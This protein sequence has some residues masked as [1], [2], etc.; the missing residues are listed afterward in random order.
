MKSLL[1]VERE[2]LAAREPPAALDKTVHRSSLLVPELPG[3]HSVISFL[4]HFLIKRGISEVS[5]RIT[6]VDNA[7][8]RI[9]QRMIPVNQHRV[10][11]IDLAPLFPNSRPNNYIVEFYSAQ[12]LAIPF[13][14]VMVNHFGPNTV[15]MV[16]AYNRV[17]N[18]VF[19]QDGE[20]DSAPAE[21][22]IDLRIDKDVDT[23]VVFTSGPTPFHGELTF[24]LS[25]SSGRRTA[26]LSLEMPRLTQ[27][28][29]GLK[30]VFPDLADGETGI[31][32]VHAPR[33]FLFFGRMLAGQRTADGAIAANHTYYDTSG[34][35][36]YFPNNA[37]SW[38]IHPFM[39]ELRNLVRVYPF[40]S[41][42][43]LRFT[44]A[45]NDHHGAEVD[46]FPAGELVSPSDEF[47]TADVNAALKS[48]GIDFESVGGFVLEAT[49]VSGNTPT[50]IPHQRVFG[51]GGLEASVVMSM[52]NKNHVP[53][54]RGFVWGQLIDGGDFKSY[55]GVSRTR[56]A[57]PQAKLLLQLYG[58]GGKVCESEIAIPP[59]SGR[60]F[61]LAEL[62]PEND[63][64][65]GNPAFLWYLI[66]GP[67]PDFWAHS[68]V[69]DR[70][71]NCTA[72]H[73]FS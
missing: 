57:D 55:L 73:A 11:A 52:D 26:S 33:Q 23:F 43:H 27:R 21:S 72:E 24:E 14:A 8:K 38:F 36:E 39:P 12:N 37:P 64:A 56:S 16:H 50:R 48:K 30:E 61:K 58:E 29:I 47:F 15:N 69:T 6:A 66:T 62:L 49:P 25:N 18:D 31:L 28:S 67:K 51:A 59:G 70:N 54:M 4:N 13:P 2:R 46:R 9:G 3:H 17:L 63:L 68:V 32:R 71:G 5:C 53:L 60:S 41:P 65:V 40:F 22:S 44:V 45:V 7:G 10:Y 19:E 35:R 20:E 34:A 42:S 1:E